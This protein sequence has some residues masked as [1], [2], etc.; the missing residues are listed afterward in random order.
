MAGGL[1]PRVAIYNGLVQQVAAAHPGTVS[2]VPLHQLVCPDGQVRSQL[3]GVTVR[4]PDGLHYPYFSFADPDAADPDTVAQVTSFGNW[5]GP[6]I[7]PPLLNP[8][9]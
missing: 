2:V 5:I 3:D 6:R 7:L 1:A 4:A 8:R 9:V